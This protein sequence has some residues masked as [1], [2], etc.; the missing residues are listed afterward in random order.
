ME[1]VGTPTQRESFQREMSNESTFVGSVIRLFYIYS[2]TGSLH[3]YMSEI[4]RGSGGIYR[5][6]FVLFRW[7][8]RIIKEAT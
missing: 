4:D 6:K 3:A 5:S 7:L 2:R 1:L 8:L